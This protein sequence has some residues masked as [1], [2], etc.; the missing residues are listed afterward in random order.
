MKTDATETKARATTPELAADAS[1]DTTMKTIQAS[2]LKAGDK[3]SRFGVAVT[4]ESI[5]ER[6][7]P[8]GFR[9]IQV[10]HSSGTVDYAIK[11]VVEVEI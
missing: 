9:T 7:H 4:V 6:N 3:L 5:A 1:H 10:R 11:A 2:D 8:L